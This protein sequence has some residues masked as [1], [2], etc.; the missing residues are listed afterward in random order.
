MA[1][2]GDHGLPAFHLGVA[3]H[4]PAQL[5]G[6]Q[7]HAAHFDRIPD[8]ALPAHQAGFGPPA[9]AGFGVDGGEVAGAE[10]DEGVIGVEERD[11]DLA[12][13]A[14]GQGLAA[15]E[16]A[17][18][19]DDVI[20]DVPAVF[21]LAFVAQV[22]AFRRAVPLAD[23]DAAGVDGGP[24]GGRQRFG[25][26]E[27]FFQ[28]ERQTQGF[29]FF[30]Q[31]VEVGGQPDVAVHLQVVEQA[32]LLLLV[33][34][35]AGDD[36]AADG[37]QPLLEHGARRGEVVAEGVQHAVALAEMRGAQGA[38][39]T[40]VVPAAG[41][42]VV[43]WAGGLENALEVAGFTGQKAAEGRAGRLKFRQIVLA[44]GGQ[45]VEVFEGGD[46]LRDQ[47]GFLQP[48]GKSG[49]VFGK[50]GDQIGEVHEGGG[51]ELGS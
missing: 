20:G 18:L 31:G 29:G 6:V 47:A 34:H 26:D 24:Q 45:A 39:P 12:G 13:L 2:A 21:L 36:G 42:G 33:A 25:G 43:N 23:G 32:H 30:Q 40:P 27:G 19:H 11:H 17:N 4:Q 28:G 22:A 5:P 50:V 1:A 49:G 41:L 7:E 35:A 48:A 15:V 10:A 37:H 51:R 44:D 8:A 3:R 38:L 14:R 16:V 9:G 46:F